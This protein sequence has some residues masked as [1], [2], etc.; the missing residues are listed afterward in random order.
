MQNFKIFIIRNL[1]LKCREKLGDS[2][3]LIIYFHTAWYST[4]VV[5][6]FPQDTLLLNRVRLHVSCK[7]IQVPILR[8][9]TSWHKECPLFI[10]VGV[11]SGGRLHWVDADSWSQTV[12]RNEDIIP[13]NRLTP[14]LVQDNPQKRRWD[15]VNA[16]YNETIIAI[17][18]KSKIFGRSYGKSPAWKWRFVVFSQPFTPRQQHTNQYEITFQKLH[19]TSCW[20]VC[21]SSSFFPFQ[22]CPFSLSLLPSAASTF[23]SLSSEGVDSAPA[24]LEDTYQNY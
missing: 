14:T 6:S 22:P 7:Q 3:S 23:N 13:V 17:E 11:Y 2:C 9:S 10:S 20:W 21:L 1:T 24:M 19:P 16:K 5:T 12:C 4:A 8:V 18:K 15:G